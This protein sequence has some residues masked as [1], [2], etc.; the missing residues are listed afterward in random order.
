VVQ[1]SP[2][3]P[4]ARHTPHPPVTLEEITTHLT[5]LAAAPLCP[6][7]DTTV[8]A[9]I[10]DITALLPIL[11]RLGD[12]L[13]AAR[14]DNANLRAA[15]GAALGAAEDG[16]PDPLDYLRWELPEHHGASPNLGRGRG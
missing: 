13:A 7:C 3:V 14:L 6:R 8:T 11:A 12:Q 15:I 1:L 16:E 5:A 10:A 2:T 9:V 4:P